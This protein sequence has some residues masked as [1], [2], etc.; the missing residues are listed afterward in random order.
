M[1]RIREDGK[2][3]VHIPF[4]ILKIVFSR[5]ENKRIGVPQWGGVRGRF[6]GD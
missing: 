6:G 2:M 1:Y 3:P 5:E 4:K